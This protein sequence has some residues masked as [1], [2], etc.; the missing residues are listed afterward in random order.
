[1]NKLKDMFGPKGQLEEMEL[2]LRAHKATIGQCCSCVH[3]QGGHSSGMSM[4]C[5]FCRLRLPWSETRFVAKN[6]DPC[7]K[8]EEVP[9]DW[10]EE[11]IARIM[12]A[13]E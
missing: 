9:I 11:A 1:M 4:D 2:Y 8:Y 13:R 10:L 6:P 12:R 3:H 7:P 5:G